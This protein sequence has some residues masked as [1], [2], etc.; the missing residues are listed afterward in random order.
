MQQ[1]DIILAEE[2]VGVHV[3]ARGHH[4]DPGSPVHVVTD[5]GLVDDSEYHEEPPRELGDAVTRGQHPSFRDDGTAALGNPPTVDQPMHHRHERELA[6]VRVT[7]TGDPLHL[8]GFSTIKRYSQKT[9]DSFSKSRR[10]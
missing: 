5:P 10:K 1:P 3:S 4:R 7:S 9:V 2:V 6:V 8:L